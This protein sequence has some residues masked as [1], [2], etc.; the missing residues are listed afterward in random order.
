MLG[1]HGIASIKKVQAGTRVYQDL[2]QQ[3]KNVTN[4]AMGI[5]AIAVLF[6]GYKLV[7]GVGDAFKFA[8]GQQ[9]SEE[10][11]AEESRDKAVLQQHLDKE[12]ETSTLTG[13]EAQNLATSFYNAFLNTQPE[14]SSNLWDEGTDENSIYEALKVLKNRADWL[15][16]SIKYGMPRRRSLASELNYELS[17]GEMGKARAILAK[18]NVKI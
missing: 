15:Q 14:W 7:S 2:N 18:I 9:W 11:K 8:T 16:V 3:S 6:V 4:I 5:G 1:V 12:A 13:D 10:R 17:A